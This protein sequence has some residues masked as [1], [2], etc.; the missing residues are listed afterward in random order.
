MARIENNSD[1]KIATD[2]TQES[3]TA[4]STKN[5][6]GNS[7]ITSDENSLSAVLHDDRGIGKVV[8]SKNVKI[9]LLSVACFLLLF[10]AVFFCPR[11]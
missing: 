8:V 5:V 11:S 1:C 9:L 4:T 3:S 2:N 10:G 6:K 7:T